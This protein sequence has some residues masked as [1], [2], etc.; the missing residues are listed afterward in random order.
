V[1]TISGIKNRSI[2][3]LSIYPEKENNVIVTNTIRSGMVNIFASVYNGIV[4]ACLGIPEVSLIKRLSNRA[5][6][7]GTTAITRPSQKVAKWRRKQFGLSIDPAY[8]QSIKQEMT[9]T[10]DACSSISV[11][12]ARQQQF[13]KQ[14]I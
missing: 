4:T 6:Q 7:V 1:P 3:K 13:I 12:L 2:G 11:Q 10:P 8:A 9:K 14:K 5:I